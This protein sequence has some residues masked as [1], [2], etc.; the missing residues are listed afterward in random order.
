MVFSNSETQDHISIQKTF[1][2]PYSWLARIRWS[3]KR[4]AFKAVY[5][6]LMFVDRY[7]LKNGI[8]L[9]YDS[10]GTSFEGIYKKTPIG[11]QPNAFT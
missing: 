10:E 4:V 6:K 3:L 7:Q 1:V 11:F 9:N 2:V 8:V 5:S